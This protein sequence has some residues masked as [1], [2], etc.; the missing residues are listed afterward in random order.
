MIIIRIIRDGK[1][2]DLNHPHKHTELEC[3]VLG[4]NYLR[5]FEEERRGKLNEQL[6]RIRDNACDLIGNETRVPCPN[7]DQELGQMSR[8]HCDRCYIKD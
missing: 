5:G 3:V 4:M 8:R 2:M 6:F 1:V 7:H